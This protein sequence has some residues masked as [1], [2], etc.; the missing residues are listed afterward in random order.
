MTG[1]GKSIIIATFALA[2]SL[3]GDFGDVITSTQYLAP[4]DWKEFQAL[5]SAFWVPS[6][7]IAYAYPHKSDFSGVILY[8]TNMDFEFAL[9]RDGNS[10][11]KCVATIPLD[12]FSEISRRPDITIV[13]ESVNVFLDGATNSVIM[14]YTATNHFEWIYLP[15]YEAICCGIVSVSQIRHCQQDYNP[16]QYRAA[17]LTDEMLAIWFGSA[18]HARDDLQL[19]RDYIKTID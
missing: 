14:S 7:T 19:G 9:L 13:D 5:F 11:D 15:L 1:E 2:A 4:C 10:L 6:S 8:G 16:Q 17:R 18:I 12:G 3:T